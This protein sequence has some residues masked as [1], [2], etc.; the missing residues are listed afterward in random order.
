MKSSRNHGRRGFTSLEL[1]VIIALLALL[2][3]VTLPALSRKEARVQRAQCASNLRQ[4]GVAIHV[5]SADANDYA[6][7]CGWPQSQNPWQTYSAARV[8]A[9]ST[10]MSRG[11]M[12]LGLLF[13]TGLADARLFYC[14]ADGTA[15]RSYEYYSAIAGVWPSTPQGSG[16]DMVRTGYNYY[17]QLRSKAL[18]FGY[19][20]PRLVFSNVQLEYGGAFFMV[21]PKLTDLDPQKS[22]TTDLVHD[23]GVS[24]HQVYGSV[25]GLNALFSDGTVAFQSART[26]PDSFDPSLW[27]GIGNDPLD[28]RIVMNSWKQ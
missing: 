3:A 20:L 21:A 28:F 1:V 13:R 14:P 12:S 17:P 27:T 10:N 8:V 25:A 23:V 11:F 16:D 2:A 18:T 6:P 7:I 22:I 19:L 5:Y 26:Q 15:L 4:I 24:P 9:G